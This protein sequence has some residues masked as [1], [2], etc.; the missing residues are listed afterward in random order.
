MDWYVQYMALFLSKYVLKSVFFLEA[1]FTQYHTH[2]GLFS[3]S[4]H[5]T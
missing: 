3:I 2:T 1:S 5:F 4:K